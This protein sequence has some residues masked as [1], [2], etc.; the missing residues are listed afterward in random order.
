MRAENIV[1]HVEVW[2]VVRQ[3]ETVRASRRMCS[4]LKDSVTK[5]C[6]FISR[7]KHHKQRMILA[8]K[9]KTG[10]K[11]KQ[12][13]EKEKKRKEGKNGEKKNSKTKK[14]EQKGV[15]KRQKWTT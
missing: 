7:I 8:K 4:G 13:K 11:G 14:E 3:K 5:S 9:E 6:K 10:K 12:R 1:R 2:S 15:P